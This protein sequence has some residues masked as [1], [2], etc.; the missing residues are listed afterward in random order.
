M[1]VVVFPNGKENTLNRA[2]TTPMAG[3]KDWM[4]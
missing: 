1:S 3:V 4:K 2:N